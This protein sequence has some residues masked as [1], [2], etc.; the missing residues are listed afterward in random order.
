MSDTPDGTVTKVAGEFVQPPGKVAFVEIKQAE[1][2]PSGETRYSWWVTVDRH[3]YSDKRGYETESDALQ[4]AGAW[5]AQNY[6]QRAIVL[7]E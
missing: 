5:V 1:V 6:P 4:A 3:P 7:K 2:P